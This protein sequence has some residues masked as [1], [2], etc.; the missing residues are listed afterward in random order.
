MSA[1]PTARYIETLLWPDTPSGMQIF[2]IPAITPPCNNPDHLFP[3]TSKENMQDMRGKG[4]I[5]R[6]KRP[7]GR[8]GLDRDKATAGRCLTGTGSGNQPRSAK[9]RELAKAYGSMCIAQP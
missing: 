1:T 2:Y 8:N 3:G 6:P 5:L 4:G 9:R 7:D